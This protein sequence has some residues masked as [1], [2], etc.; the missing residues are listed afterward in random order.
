MKTIAWGGWNGANI[1]RY[2]DGS[3]L[4]L[5]RDCA[6]DDSEASRLF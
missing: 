2:Q 1:G 3:V 5:G 4:R 6:Q